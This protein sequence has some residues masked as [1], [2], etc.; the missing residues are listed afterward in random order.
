MN[1][2]LGGLNSENLYIFIDEL[3]YGLRRRE[4]GTGKWL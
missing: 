4:L 1:E 2:C 3:F